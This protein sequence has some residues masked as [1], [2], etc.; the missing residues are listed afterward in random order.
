MKCKFYLL[1]FA[2]TASIAQAQTNDFKKN[3][4]NGNAKIKVKAYDLAI[5]DFGAAIKINQAEIDKLLA[6]KKTLPAEKLYMIEPYLKRAICYFLTG[7][8]SN[9][10]SDLEIVATFDTSNTESKAIKAN[11]LAK[12]QKQKGCAQ[13]RTEVSRGSLIAKQAFEDCFCWSEGVNLHKEA[14]TANN[15]KKYDDAIQKLSIAKQIL[16]DS[17]F[18]YAEMAKS[19]MGKGDHQSALN[20]LNLA[21]G[22]KGNN[23]K[24]FLMRGEALFKLDSLNMAMSDLNKCMDM[25]PNFYEGHLLRAD[26]CEKAEKWNA[27][28]FDLEKCIKL[29]PD[30][31]M[32]Y[33]RIALIRHNHLEDLFGAC[34]YYKMALAREVEEA[35]EM[36][37]NCD[38]PKYMKKNQKKATSD[39]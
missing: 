12:S 9:A 18:V 1:L 7:S 4:D 26:I 30:N 13:L 32:L 38:S 3:L 21:A 23:Y 19:L 33:Y 34:E 35:R 2:L 6:T 15:L 28:I 25:K 24:T 17:G 16:P 14:T 36:C 10:K 5:S 11:D 22:M 31:G 8:S 29:K 37:T 20:E 39:N 27:A